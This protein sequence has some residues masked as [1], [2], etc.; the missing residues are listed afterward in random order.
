[1]RKSEATDAASAERSILAV[2][3]SCSQMTD[4]RCG[5]AATRALI[6]VFAKNEALVCL[7]AASIF[8]LETCARQQ[9]IG[10]NSTRKICC[11]INVGSF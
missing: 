10:H 3:T 7:G 8:L 6:Y 11:M 1:M 4:W 2:A 5:K 9:F